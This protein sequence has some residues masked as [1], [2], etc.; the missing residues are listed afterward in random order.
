M[1][2]PRKPLLNSK[3]SPQGF[4]F[5]SIGE[6]MIELAPTETADD[7]HMGYA[8]DTFNTAWYMRALRPD[9][10]VRY[11]TR[12]GTDEVSDQMLSMMADAGINTAHI[13][14]DT[15]RSVGLYM[16]SLN[17]GE[18][19]FSYWRDR[20]AAK[21]LAQD[22]AQLSAAIDEADVVYFSGISLAILDLDGRKSLLEV[23]SAARAQG[24]TIAFDSNLRPRL[25]TSVD[26]MTTAIMAAAAVSDIILPS[27]DDEATFF[28]DTDIEAT[29]ERYLRVGAKT[30]IVKNGAGSV[31]YVH[32]GQSGTVKPSS[33]SRVVDTTSAGDSFNAGFFAGLDRARSIEELIQTAT[34]VA[35][36][37]IGRKG[38]LVELDLDKIEI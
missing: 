12:V 28:N 30:I 22:S 31:Y 15:E 11:V 1:L 20:S 6:C 10:E 16:I 33:A 24:K 27:Y 14:R 34:Q 9:T 37:V 38:A 13:G 4:S 2:N 32:D 17:N 35:A 19:S 18:R 26:E 21:K 25:W 36:Q 8:G 23:L 7:F 5:A 29:S 3:T